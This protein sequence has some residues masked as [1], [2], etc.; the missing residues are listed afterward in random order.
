MGARPKAIIEYRDPG[1]E[2]P[3][4]A[5]WSGSALA[6]HLR[7]G[8]LR[9]DDGRY[10]AARRLKVHAGWDFGN[11]AAEPTYPLPDVEEPAE[12][13]TEE[14]TEASSFTAAQLRENT[15]ADLV[16]LAWDYFDLDLKASANKD[17]L[18]EAILIA[19]G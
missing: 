4:A 6:F 11:E 7:S 15:K 1:E 12:E 8:D 5:R 13:T 19:Q 10:Y 3:E 14:T 9:E 2:V 18:V 17:S 16:Q